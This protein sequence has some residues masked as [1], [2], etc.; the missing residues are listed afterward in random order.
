MRKK[1]EL[2]VKNTILT[3]EGRIFI[4]D[5]LRIS[6]LKYL[7]L[8]HPAVSAVK[9]LTRFYVWWPAINEDFGNFVQTYKKM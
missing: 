9:A 4:S 8:E 5:D 3:R 1:D 7:H 6:V 2:F